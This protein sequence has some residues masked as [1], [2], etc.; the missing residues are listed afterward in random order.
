MKDF[1][2]VKTCLGIEFKQNARQQT[3]FMSQEKYIDAILRKYGMEDCKPAITPIESKSALKRPENP[4]EE[5]MKRY[6]YQ[7]LIGSLMFLAVSTRPD[8]AF[9]VNFLS[10]FNSNY[11]AEHWKASKRILRYLKGQAF[12]LAGASI[13]WEARKQR[14][15]ALSSTESEYLAMSEAVKEALYLKALL[16]RIGSTCD[17][18]RIS[19]TTRAH[20]NW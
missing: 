6:P 5:E 19:T 14:T 1:G 4:D 13:S 15:V 3:V 20:N 9:A 8:I 2:P 17:S 10:Q 7:S 16:N 18:I 12:I 11:S